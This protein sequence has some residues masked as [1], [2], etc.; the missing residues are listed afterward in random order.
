M[1]NQ[2]TYSK[3]PDLAVT[4][5]EI[6]QKVMRPLIQTM[7]DGV[8][9]GAKAK[10][11]HKEVLEAVGGCGLDKKIGL[12]S[13]P[14]SN[15][16]RVG[17]GFQLLFTEGYLEYSLYRDAI[18]IEPLIVRKGLSLEGMHNRMQAT[19][20]CTTGDK[21][22]KIYDNGCMSDT[23]GDD[24]CPSDSISMGIF[25]TSVEEMK[26]GEIDQLTELINEAITTPM[27]D[28]DK[29]GSNTGYDWCA[30]VEKRFASTKKRYPFCDFSG[31]KNSPE[32]YHAYIQHESGLTSLIRIVG[33]KAKPAIAE[34]DRDPYSN[35]NHQFLV[36]LHAQEDGTQFFS[37]RSSVSE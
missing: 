24:P 6:A 18:F 5:I 14:V 9:M 37:L 27:L 3:T 23:G 4:P 12:I 20:C 21:C 17:Y 16:S 1:N 15:N 22:T 34:G 26:T 36:D 7:S 19:S 28:K 10:Y 32:A 30:E 11:M 25:E 35:F 2:T 29:S 13:G 33:G 31:N 8:S